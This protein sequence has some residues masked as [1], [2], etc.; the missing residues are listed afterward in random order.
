[1][2]GVSED[3][4][5]ERVWEYFFRCRNYSRGKDYQTTGVLGEGG[6]YDVR[7]S[8][9][10]DLD[11]ILSQQVHDKQQGELRFFWS[12]GSVLFCNGLRIS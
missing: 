5:K 11:Q 2:F 7:L 3:V 6:V 8:T 9:N 4:E 12:G 1:M 10:W